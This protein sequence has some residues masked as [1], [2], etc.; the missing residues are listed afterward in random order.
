M[1]QFPSESLQNNNLNHQLKHFES[2]LLNQ[3]GSVEMLQVDKYPE[4][5]DLQ[6]TS[7][8]HSLISAPNRT[9]KV[10]AA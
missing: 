6:G 10:A 1:E 9:R 5:V 4:N 2:I 8:Q 3:S 7:W